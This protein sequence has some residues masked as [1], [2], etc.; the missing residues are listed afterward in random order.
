M[1]KDIYADLVLLVSA[2]GNV[3]DDWVAYAAAC[4]INEYTGRPIIGRINFNPHYLTSDFDL[5]FDSFGTVMHEVTHVMVFSSNLWE[6]FINW[7][8]GARRKKNEIEQDITAGGTTYKVIKTPRVLAFVR[9]HFDCTSLA[10]AALENSGDV[11]TKN[12]HWEKEFF[13]NEYMTSATVINPVMSDLT[14]AL[15]VDSGWYQFRE[16]SLL[17][18]GNSLKTEAFSWLI[19]EKCDVYAK[20]CPISGVQCSIDGEAGCSYDRTFQG[21]CNAVHAANNCKWYTP[22]NFWDQDCRVSTNQSASQLTGLQSFGVNRR[23]FTGKFYNGKQSLC[24]LPRCTK[25]GDDW[26]LE[27]QVGGQGWLH[28]ETEGQVLN[29]NYTPEGKTTAVIG[30]VYCPTNFDKFC[31]I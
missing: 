9:S 27:I 31:D 20:Q 12:S 16:N 17:P 22:T 29:A 25:V 19:N 24:Y 6:Y 4:Q 1:E 5:F 28:C 21:S 7:E 18:N 3:T 11:G 15:F 30:D 26:K 14:W 8:A 13:G 10:G 2:E 23:C